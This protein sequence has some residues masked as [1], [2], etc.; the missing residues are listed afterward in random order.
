[1]TVIP[2]NSTYEYIARK[3]RRLTASSSQSA[4]SDG[5]L[6]EYV[7]NFFNQNFPNT[8]KT[9]QMR[10]VYT[11]YTQ[12]YVDRYPVDINYW[13]GF[14]FPLYVDG[15]QGMFFK[16]RQQFFYMWPK[17]PTKFQ[18]APTSLSGTIIAATQSNPC[19]ITSTAHGLATGA[20]ITIANVVGMV[21]LNGIT[22]TI[23][24]L[25]ANNF[26]LDG[27][28]S[29]AFTPYVSGG[30]WTANSQS[31]S[32]T[33]SNVPFFSKSVTIGGISATGGTI[34]IADDGNGNLQYM[35]VNPQTSD[36]LQTTFPAVPGM[37][38]QNNNNPGLINVVNIGTVDYITGVMAFVLPPG[39][40]LASGELLNIF[41]SQY[42]TGRPYTL[43]FWNNELTI[44]PVPKLVHKIE[45]EAYQTPV[46]FLQTTDNPIV[47]QWCKYIAYGTAIDILTDRQDL[48][49]VQ[50]LAPAFD[51]QEG[52][53]LERQGVE[54][55]GQR[56]NTI[57]SSSQQGQGNYWG[58][59]GNWY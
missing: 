29:T 32:F 22:Y 59:W 6:D 56:N 52:L 18:Q 33:I 8:I 41:V 11:F 16:D 9:D 4:L 35:T 43:M 13:Q 38:N 57:F 27:V 53:I 14:R 19:Q 55:I 26:T 7:N 51:E 42:T 15:I 3:V 28:D 39:V 10:A 58:S 37:Y 45:I 21:Q 48:A 5:S 17:W 20:V 31:F 40:S 25:D 54:E 44:R 47:N 30:T 12:P 34:Q 49:G 24:V 1:M 36:P 46:Q 2:A 50:N 23:T